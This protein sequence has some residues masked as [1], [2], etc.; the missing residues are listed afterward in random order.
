VP[1]DHAVALVAAGVV[2]YV[3]LVAVSY[4]RHRAARVVRCPVAHA[5]ARVH[6][7]AW[8]AALLLTPSEQVPVRTCSLWPER[9]HCLQWCREPV[10]AAKERRTS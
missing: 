6:L 4:L 8:R 9:G 7:D 2:A 3:A 5:P 1:D 10:M